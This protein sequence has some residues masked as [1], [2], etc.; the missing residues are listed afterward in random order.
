M[1]NKTSF[2]HRSQ[3]PESGVLYII[4]T[5]IGNLNDISFRALKILKNV[6]LVYCEDTRETKKIL[7]KYDVK[8]KLISFN[9]HNSINKIKGVISDLKNGESIALVSDAGMPSICDPGEHLVECAWSNEIEVIC[10]PGPCAALT[11]LVSSGMPASSFIF[12]GFFKE[13]SREKTIPF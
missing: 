12:E 10:V 2:S 8:N 7:N 6:S 9:K 13:K 4:G 5:P 3:E 11:A 1:N